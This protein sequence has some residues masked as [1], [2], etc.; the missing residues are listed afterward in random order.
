MNKRLL[1]GE[2]IVNIL[3]DCVLHH[4]L[5]SS[6]NLSSSM[7]TKDKSYK[8][9]RNVFFIRDHDGIHD[10]N[11]ESPSAELTFFELSGK[12]RI[13][14]KRRSAVWAF[15]FH[16]FNPILLVLFPR[17]DLLRRFSLPHRVHVH[18]VRIQS[19][20]KYLSQRNNRSCQTEARCSTMV[21]RCSETTARNAASHDGSDP[22]PAA[23]LFPDG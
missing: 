23:R 13:N 11:S 17:N 22:L 19:R 1:Y 2:N 5:N 15:D 16:R 6:F 10:R 18:H 20:H 21:Y 8:F 9:F 14:F 3:L 12:R 7:M 4:L